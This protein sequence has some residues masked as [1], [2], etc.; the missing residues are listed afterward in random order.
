[1]AGTMPSILRGGALTLEPTSM[2][3][4]SSLTTSSNVSSTSVSASGSAS[5][6]P[7]VRLPLPGIPRRVSYVLPA[8]G[9][10]ASKPP[11]R[12]LKVFALPPAL[13]AGEHR[14]SAG[15]LLI[16]SHHQSARDLQLD[17]W[18]RAERH[19]RHSLAV[20]SLAVDSTTRIQHGQLSNSHGRDAR[21]EGILYTGGR[22][23]LVCAWELGLPMR[24]A[25]QR[26]R[27]RRRKAGFLRQHEDD[28]E[29]G[30]E[31]EDEDEEDEERDRR[32]DVELDPSLSR[33]GGDTSRTDGLLRPHAQE[34]EEE[35]GE[36]EP[37]PDWEVDPSQLAQV[38]H[39]RRTKFRQCLQSHTDWIND[40]ILCNYNQTVVSASSDRTIKIWNPH[41]PATSLLP[42]TLG[43]HSDY[44]R[45]LAHAPDAKAVISGGLDRTVKVWDLN[46]ASNRSNRGVHSP[47][48]PVWELPEQTIGQSVYALATTPSASM[49]AVGTPA[50]TIRLWD[51]RAQPKAS[52]IANLI[53]HTDNVR[54]LLISK[55]GRHL[56]SGSSDSTIRL[57][58]IGEQRCLHTFT[59]HNDSVWSLFSADDNLDVFYSGDR[60]GY[61]CKVDLEGCGDAGEGE[62][63]V[64]AQDD[65]NGASLGA[66]GIQKIVALDNSYIWTASGSSSV[67]MWRDI[68]SRLDREAEFPIGNGTNDFSGVPLSATESFRRR[69]ADSPGASPK[70][71]PVS[72]PS[73]GSPTSP[74]GLE[75]AG[76]RANGRQHHGTSETSDWQRADVPAA[77]T[78][79]GI[80][81]ESLV[82]LAPASDPYGAAVGLGST[83]I[84]DLPG[85]LGRASLSFL[86]AS[87]SSFAQFGRGPS[88]S[89]D[90]P[91]NSGY[92]S[93]LATTRSRS[94]FEGDTSQS[95]GLENSSPSAVPSGPGAHVSFH[96]GDPLKKDRSGSMIRFAP[97]ID[98]SEI[99]GNVGMPEHVIE[100]EDLDGDD[101]DHLDPAV[102]ARLAY[103][104]RELAEDAK[105]LRSS[106]AETI[107]GTHGL[108]R[109]AMLNDRRH[110][111]T[112]DSKGQLAIWDILAA[113]ML[114]VIDDGDIRAEATKDEG[115]M[116]AMMAK[117]RDRMDKLSPQSIPA[118]ILELVK[119]RL[120]G[121]GTCAPWCTVDVKVGALTVHLEEPRCFDAEIY[122]DECTDFIDPALCQDDRR[123]NVGKWILRNLFDNFIAAEVQMR[124]EERASLLAGVPAFEHEALFS[125]RPSRVSI[126]QRG[127]NTE[128]HEAVYTPGVTIA[129]AATAASPVVSRAT[130]RRSTA[131]STLRTPTADQTP[132]GPSGSVLDYF[133]MANTS[134]VAS[135]ANSRSQ[136]PLE[137]VSNET[138]GTATTPGRWTSLQLGG[139][140]ALT[141]NTST[142]SKAGV[143]ISGGSGTP[144][145]PTG[146]FMGRL[147]AGLGNKGS[148][149]KGN[150][151]AEADKMEAK[152]DANGD[153]EKLSEPK[154]AP[155]VMALR[156]L[157]GRVLN[158]TTLDD[159]PPLCFDPEMTVMISEAIPEIGSWEV[160][161]RGL[162]GCTGCDVSAL[163]LTCPVWLLEF[164]LASRIL[165]RDQAANKLSFTL[166]PW[167]DPE[168]SK[169]G[170]WKPGRGPM[171]ALPSGSVRLS[172][173]RMLRMRKV[174]MYVCEKLDLL[175]ARKHQDS[176]AGSIRSNVDGTR[177]GT[178][179]GMTAMPGRANSTSGTSQ[180]G[181]SVSDEATEQEL[182]RLELAKSIEIL[183]GG[184]VLKPES[185]L[186]QCQRFYHRAGGDIKLEYRQRQATNT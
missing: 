105:V 108:I 72:L 55:D 144:S 114:G 58:S 157:L 167:V 127:G 95:I 84:R 31:D 98:T 178:S 136:T 113:Q 174:S 17:Q 101:E 139:N 18:D 68:P 119:S 29:E 66:G 82:S 83:S 6:P 35:E 57:W 135:G 74:K 165:A 9:S 185:T 153:G 138:G 148:K 45:C 64:L 2:S 85:A 92:P 155:H 172:A 38:G 173:T 27:K 23:G 67:R 80:P 76:P 26:P 99:P 182:A 86:N 102:E 4:S 166:Q 129:I 134:N 163:E 7:H 181:Q 78:L 53:G 150:K 169:D 40:I 118:D 88:I 133:S 117:R 151:T 91:G 28:V 109:C 79:Y 46:L 62:C 111:L 103:E 49:I 142:L 156:Q 137:V 120:E 168:A 177:T 162:V 154:S 59:H 41:D 132:L 77:M 44:V 16:P 3:G 122:L 115:C 42:S 51:P 10:T 143:D 30:D 123:I 54:A 13:G 90:R 52:P 183:Y 47:D 32:I 39:K 11:H 81:F 121:E 1:M 63:V 149:D 36:E 93:A 8:P 97:H 126:T 19:P 87:R 184:I 176:I 124:V 96:A 33:A 34:E 141:L 21:P 12:P 69:Y 128:Q 14:P 104:D 186:A 116:A 15:P 164:T 37:E 24:E 48:R 131:L 20:T 171:P 145:T 175:P 22:D 25:K 147:R 70:P 170:S 112:V 130:S 60:R 5:F 152:A 158:V 100:D 56:L 161:Y 73:T 50:R 107:E 179:L 106:A 125:R 71:I 65:G 110:V 180:I 160:V 94:I 43:S 61:L 75:L 159:F 89:A 146:G 140:K